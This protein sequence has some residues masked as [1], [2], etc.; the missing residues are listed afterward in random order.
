MLELSRLTPTS[1]VTLF[2]L[3]LK[4]FV[5]DVN[6]QQTRERVLA[7][8]QNYGVNCLVSMFADAA[9]SRI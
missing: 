3:L 4:Q 7:Q 9:S 5:P 6:A 1:V 2:D 8:Y